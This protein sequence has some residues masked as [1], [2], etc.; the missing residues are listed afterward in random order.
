M[1]QDEGVQVNGADR[2]KSKPIDVDYVATRVSYN[3][4]TGEFFWLPIEGNLAWNE[5]RAGKPAG[6][7]RRNGYV[8]VCID[9]RKYLGHRLAWAI[10]NGSCPDRL[11]HIDRNRAN[12]RITNLRPAT[13]SQNSFNS[14]G[15]HNKSGARG[16]YAQSN[17]RFNAR[18]TINGKTLNLGTYSTLAQAARAYRCAAI[19]LH[20]E[21]VSAEVE[22]AA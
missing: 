7:I 14:G 10:T 19:L 4:N 1:T 18:I 13:C 15:F 17:G 12:N 6:S 2:I 22:V 5:Q 16:V 21:F 20:G 8:V 11:D 9:K 3:A